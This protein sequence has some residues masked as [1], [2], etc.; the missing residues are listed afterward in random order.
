MRPALK[1]D[2]F[3]KN[4][5]SQDVFLL[6][7]GLFYVVVVNKALKNFFIRYFVRE[8]LLKIKIPHSR[9]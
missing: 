4:P 9:V 1:D 3:I 6:T 7:S 8:T 2:I 5:I